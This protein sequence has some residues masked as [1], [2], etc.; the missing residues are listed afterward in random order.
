MPSRWQIDRDLKD[1]ERILKEMQTLIS[2]LGR[3]K[4][5]LL[6][7]LSK[8]NADKDTD[9]SILVLDLPKRLNHILGRG[10]ITTVSDLLG[11]LSQGDEKLLEIELMGRGHI[12]EIKAA[13]HGH[14]YMREING[15]EAIDPT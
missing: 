15:A 6:G 11:T 12:A 9:V 7:E 14:G 2:I 5:L 4:T 13:L 1:I 3:Q 8:L 10:A